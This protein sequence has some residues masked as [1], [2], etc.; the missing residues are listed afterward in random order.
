MQ[1]MYQVI[2]QKDGT[3]DV[4]CNVG[5]GQSG[6][7]SSFSLGTGIINSE[8]DFS[9]VVNV[10]PD[11]VK[12]VNMINYCGGRFG[13]YLGCAPRPGNALVVMRASGNVEGVLWSHEF[14]HNQGLVHNNTTNALMNS[15]ISSN[16]T[17]IT[18]AND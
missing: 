17:R 4:A 12:V 7:L 11:Q 2:V 13:N 10:V 1:D 14:G 9:F 5:F 15:Y 8:I 6:N 3:D 16:T 18:A